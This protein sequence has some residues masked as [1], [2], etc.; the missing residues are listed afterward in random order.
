MQGRVDR[1]RRKPDRHVGSGRSA[2]PGRNLSDLS[3]DR[4]N[5]ARRR[6]SVRLATRCTIASAGQTSAA[7]RL[8]AAKM[9]PRPIRPSPVETPRSAWGETKKCPGLRREDQVDRPALPLLRHRIRHRRSAQPER[10][11]QAGQK[12]RAAT[13]DTHPGGCPVRSFDRRL[14]RAHRSRSSRRHMCSC[15]ATSSPRPGQAIWSWAIPRWA[16]P[17]YIQ[18]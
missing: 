2:Q 18:Y 12:G 9:L 4:S 7:A 3:D 13:V 8:M 6:S 16:S 10:S 17:T 15:N 11:A 5:P 14:P 1:G